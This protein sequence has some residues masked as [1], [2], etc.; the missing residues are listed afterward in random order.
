MSNSYYGCKKL[1]LHTIDDYFKKVRNLGEGAFGVVYLANTQNLA[2]TEI[3]E[4]LPD[5]VAVKVMKISGAQREAMKQEI[6]IMKHIDLPRNIKFFGCFETASQLYVI[7]DLAKGRE[8]FDYINDGSMSAQQ[9]KSV[10]REVAAGIKELHDIGVVH[11][12]IKPEN[13]MVELL[14]DGKSAN[15]RIIDYGLACLVPVE[16]SMGRNCYGMGGTQAY[17]DPKQQEGN[18]E[19]MKMGDWWAYGH[20]LYAMYTR[21]LLY[22][23]DEGRFINPG[24][25]ALNKHV[26]EEYHDLFLTLLDVDTPQVD[27]PG[28]D[29]IITEIGRDYVF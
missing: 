25:K 27:R 29:E 13:I 11:K 7:M 2:K 26:P 24:W 5:Q 23:A 17:K 1:L 12:D 20:T 28:Q 4:D 14:P 3:G 18:V 19:S 16:G 15:V 21:T 6:T 8:L 10:A 9:K 22:I